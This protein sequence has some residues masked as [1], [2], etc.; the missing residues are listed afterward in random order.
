MTINEQISN[1]ILN[2]FLNV[3]DTKNIRGNSRTK[4]L[5]IICS[6]LYK[7]R[8]N[9]Q[10]AVE[11]FEVRNKKDGYGRTFDIDILITTKEGNKHAILAKSIQS[12]YNK[13]S[14]NYTNTMVGE[15]VRALSSTSSMKLERLA[16][17]NFVPLVC[18][19]FN[20]NKVKWQET[21]HITSN[22]T[23]KELITKYDDKA[24]IINIFYKIKEYKKITSKQDFLDLTIEQIEIIDI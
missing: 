3:S 15:I 16:F 5:H 14:N 2:T 11:Q 19:C 10:D 20:G 12:N 7:T 21:K 18:P 9:L 17:I 8:Y 1:Y 13:N 23:I 4:Q 24:E 22:E 6:D